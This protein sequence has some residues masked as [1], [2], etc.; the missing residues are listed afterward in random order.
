MTSFSL[1][2][3]A[4]AALLVLALAVP[5]LGGCASASVAEAYG[6]PDPFEWTYFR[7]APTDVV[8]AIGVA[9]QQSGTRIESVRNEDAGVVITLSSRFGSADFS[10]IL[11][12]GTDV[13]DYTARAQIYPQGRPLP[14][15]LEADISGR[16]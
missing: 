10:Q 1:A 11:V 15:W 4:P 8:E 2:G 13:E 7:G 16:I 9:F 12:Q 6:L 14:R 5:T 3:R